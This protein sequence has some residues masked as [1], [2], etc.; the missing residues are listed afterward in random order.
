MSEK[1]LIIGPAW[2]GDMVMAQSLF[3]TLKRLNRDCTIDVLAPAWT[4]PLIER[5][6]EIRRAVAAPFDHGKFDIGGR[7]RLGWE[8]AREGYDR[9][10]VLPNS[11][12]SA[13]VPF[14]AGVPRRTGWRGEMRYGLLN[15]VRILDKP[16]FPLMIDR[17]DALAFDRGMIGTAND[18][19]APHPAP[20]LSVTAHSVQSARARYDL[21]LEAPVL[22]LCPG[23]EFG[24]SK[25]WPEDRFA[26]VAAQKLAAGWQVWLFGS[27]K[28]APVCE[29]IRAGLEPE[30]QARCTIL[31]G[32]TSLADAVDLLSCAGAVVSND[33]GLMH[34]A[35][36]LDRP[37]VAVYGSTSPT[38]T[39]PLTDHK[40]IVRL[41]LECSPCFKRE[42]PL[43]HHDCMRKLPAAM[44]LD[45]IAELEGAA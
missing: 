9:A 20:R 17:F 10:I 44:V 21:T 26:E 1:I 15:D 42:C 27:A 36:A 43:G 16:R 11:W 2:V 32:R 33:S 22:A 23:A 4:A 12:K 40:R 14:F 35:A 6:P 28:D 45:A 18:F 38:F 19:P 24:S 39:P 5:M 41:G 8:L 37:L 7:W 25:R 34:V 3:M 30:A 31:A 13:L 29:A